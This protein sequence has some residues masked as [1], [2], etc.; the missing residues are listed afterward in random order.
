[1]NRTLTLLTAL[2]LAPLGMLHAT[3][4]HVSACGNDA[5][6]GTKAEPFAT[7]ERARAHIE[8]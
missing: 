6:P 7:L 5:N 3:E 8:R 2:L 4:F 1:M